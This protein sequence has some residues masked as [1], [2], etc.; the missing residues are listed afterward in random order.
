MFG[1]GTGMSEQRPISFP[2][3][4]HQVMTGPEFTVKVSYVKG[5]KQARAPRASKSGLV[6][7]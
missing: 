6:E 4:G 7:N 1:L 5:T 3:S 2:V